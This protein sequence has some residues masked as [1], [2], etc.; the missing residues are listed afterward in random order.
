[1]ARS[2]SP[3]AASPLPDIATNTP[4]ADADSFPIVGIGSSAGGLEPTQQLLRAVPPDL[5][6]AFVVI[7][8]LSPTY[9]SM[10]ADI[11]SR[12]TAM[13]VVEVHDAPAVEPNHV[14]VIPP[15]RSISLLDGRLALQPR[16]S[17]GGYYRPIDEF[18]GSLAQDPGHVAIGVV[19][20]GTGNDGTAGLQAIKAE[21]GITFAQDG[22]AQ[23]EGMPHSAIATGCVDFVLPPARIA[24]EIARIGKHPY[25]ARGAF[26]QRAEE[27][28]VRSDVEPVLRLL[29]QRTG[30]DF[31][32]YKFNTLFRRIN[33]RAVLL[34]LENLEQ[35]AAHLQNDPKEVEALYQDILINVTAFFRN[36]EAFEV[37][38]TDVLAGLMQARGRSEPLRVWSI[39]CS[40]GEGPTPSPSA[41]P[42]WGRNAVAQRPPRSMRPT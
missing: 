12:S 15:N 11:L 33:R 8:H 23:Q 41:S 40:T 38:K 17:V 3:S 4:A 18:F 35:Y 10:L 13:P 9:E 32:H 6:M 21:G 34:H 5:G 2:S 19:L 36:P 20:S 22:S 30:V 7:Q 14:Y 25:V 39:G 27:L 42:S 28:P 37:L 1:M 24:E 31:S 26:P 16:S 29:Q